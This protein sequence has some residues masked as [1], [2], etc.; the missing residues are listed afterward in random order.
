VSSKTFDGVWFT[1]YANDHLPPHVHGFYAE[2]EV[3]VDLLPEEKVGRSQ[4]SG[5]VDPQNAKRSDV[6]R[7]LAVASAHATALH[8][9]WEAMN[10]PV[11]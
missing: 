7:I 2:V 5:A 6:R 10:G 11:Y 3:I 9:L 8:R 1:A 4:R